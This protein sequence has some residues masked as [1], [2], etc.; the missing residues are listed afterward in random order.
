[1]SDYEHFRHN[2]TGDDWALFTAGA[3]RIGRVAAEILGEKA[4]ESR[5]GLAGSFAQTYK[6][7]G[8]DRRLVAGILGMS[9]EDERILNGFCPK[10]CCRLYPRCISTLN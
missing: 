9:P 6:G 1:M 7:H 5:I 3:V 4:S 10:L 8:T 2:R